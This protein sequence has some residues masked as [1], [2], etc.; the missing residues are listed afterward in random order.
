MK[1]SKTILPILAILLCVSLSCTLL[2]N[3]FAGG[4]KPAD[5]FRKIAKLWPVDP[6]APL[7]SP[8]SVAVRELAK[9]DPGV[10]SFASDIEA[11]ERGAMKQI[12][13]ANSA[14]PETN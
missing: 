1:N 13:A 14:T 8:G 9:I 11:T 7:V 12:I 4:E 6:K 2:K 5:E 10:A 3:K